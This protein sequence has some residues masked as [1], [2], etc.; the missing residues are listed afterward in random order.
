MDFVTTQQL[1]FR[2]YLN[3]SIY[4]SKYITS[5]NLTNFI[6]ESISKCQYIKTTKLYNL[7]QK[8]RQFFF[9]LT[10]NKTFVSNNAAAVIHKCFIV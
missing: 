5:K 1:I 3:I 7:R 4:M 8:F 2:T 10:A 9:A 6:I